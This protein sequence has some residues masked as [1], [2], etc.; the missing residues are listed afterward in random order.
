MINSKD[1]WVAAAVI[2]VS[3]LS[4]VVLWG[5]LIATPSSNRALIE[6]NDRQTKTLVDYEFVIIENQRKIIDNQEALCSMLANKRCG[7]IG[8]IP[9]KKSPP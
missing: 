3:A 6:I 4:A 5:T 2:V 1:K 9:G 8:E 7:D